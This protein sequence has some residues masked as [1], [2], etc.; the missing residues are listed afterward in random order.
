MV[1]TPTGLTRRTVLTSLPAL[2]TLPSLLGEPKETN[3]NN[4]DTDRPAITATTLSGLTPLLTTKFTGDPAWLSE[5][6]STEPVLQVLEDANYGLIFANVLRSLNPRNVDGIT[7][8]P[9]HCG[10]GD[11]LR[12]FHGVVFSFFFPFLSLRVAS[13]WES[14]FE[15]GVTL[16]TRKKSTS[17]VEKRTATGIRSIIASSSKGTLERK[18]VSLHVTPV[19]AVWLTG[20]ANP[21]SADLEQ[22]FRAA[23]KEIQRTHK[24]VQS[25]PTV[26]PCK[27][28]TGSGTFDVAAGNRLKRR[29]RRIAE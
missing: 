3:N 2:G 16:L 29:C 20:D 15:S 7:A 26:D 18:T 22:M 6:G 5:G 28:L 17:I 8:A 11:G 13:L 12:N 14:V 9:T 27:V 21:N 4:Y 25:D 19:G 1:N 23:G 24:R 10:P